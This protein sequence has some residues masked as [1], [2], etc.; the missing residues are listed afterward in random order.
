MLSQLAETNHTITVF[1]NR[2]IGETIVGTK[3]FS[4]KQFATDTA[5]LLDALHIEKADVFGASFG[6]FVAQE[7]TLNYP[8]KVGRLV[9]SAGYCGGN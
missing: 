1:D 8:E 9:L 4:I 3:P 2:G 7:L 5:G 6:S